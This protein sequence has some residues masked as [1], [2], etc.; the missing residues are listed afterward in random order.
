MASSVVSDNFET[1][2]GGVPQL[3]GADRQNQWCKAWCNYD[4]IGTAGIRDSYNIS[5]V[6][7][8]GV[9]NYSFNLTTAMPNKNYSVVTG[10]QRTHTNDFAQ[11][12]QSQN[13]TSLVRYEHF[14]NGSM[15]DTDAAWIAVF[16]S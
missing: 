6:T 3:G 4:G 10:F 8:A 15:T 12:I 5:S 9:G 7:D 14:G 13:T 16:S 1:G 11:S 2:T